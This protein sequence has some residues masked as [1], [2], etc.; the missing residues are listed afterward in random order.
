[1]SA[2]TNES[3]VRLAIEA[4]W[5]RGDL[6]AADELFSADYINHGGL[7][8]D[9]VLGPEAIKISAALH[10]LAFP[11]LRVTVEDVS[12]DQ[13]TVVLRWTA[14]SGGQMEGSNAGASNQESLTGITRSRLAGG[15]IIESWTRWRPVLRVRSRHR[16]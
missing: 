13:G 7:L 16:G 12:T 4:I 2:S 6:D 5:N 14:S 11:D 8:V 10:R 3:L 15:K 1:M 9:L